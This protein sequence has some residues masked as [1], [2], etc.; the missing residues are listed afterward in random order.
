M[1]AAFIFI[2]IGFPYL[3]SP[4]HKPLCCSFFLSIL[5][6]FLPLAVPLYPVPAVFN[7]IFEFYPYLGSFMD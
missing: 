1:P 5:R 3:Q 2:C 6:R 4:A 7:T